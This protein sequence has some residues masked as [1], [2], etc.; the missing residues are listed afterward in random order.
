MSGDGDF[1]PAIRAVQEMGV[2][3]EVIS[4]RGDTSSDLIE[5]ADLFT[6]ITQHRPVEKGS[7]RS[8][9]RVASDGEEDLS[10]TEVPD[11][12][13]EGTGS[14]RVAAV[15]AEAAVET[16][17]ISEPQSPRRPP[18]DRRAATAAGGRRRRAGGGQLVAMPGEKLSR[19]AG[20]DRRGSAWPRASSS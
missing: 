3:V 6:D 20:V 9:R 5:V 12:Q 1:A 14:R 15:A 19:A 8:G 2:R 13:S 17:P 4:F 11:K 10:M 7:S 16:P 18:H